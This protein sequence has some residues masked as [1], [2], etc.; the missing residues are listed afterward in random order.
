[1]AKDP[2]LLLREQ[3]Q[4]VW[5][6]YIRR[7]ELV[8]SEFRALVEGGITGVTSNPTIFEKAVAGSNDYDDAFR[9]FAGARLDWKQAL[10]KL[11]SDD[12]RMAADILRPVYD[13]TGGND[14]FVSIEEDPAL[15]YDTAR[16][17]KEAGR[18]REL[19]GRQNVLIKI[20]STPAGIA[21]A[22]EAIY[23]GININITLMFSLQAYEDTARAYI[24]GLQRRLEAGLPVNT[25]RSVASFF[26]SRVDTLVDKLLEEKIAAASS[27]AERDRLRAMLGKAAIANAKEAYQR[28]L[29]IFEGDEFAR[30]RAAGAAVQRVLWASTSTKNPA[31]RDILYAEQLI[32]PQTIDTM[33]PTTITGFRDHG[34]V[35]P[36]L[37][38]GIEEA[39]TTL[40]ELGKAGIDMDEVTLKLQRDGVESFAASWR[41]LQDA[42]RAKLSAVPI[43]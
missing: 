12:I 37:T 21:A 42:V 34:V 30:L 24:R 36:T 4:S 5:Y 11:V 9:E 1:M 6:D 31:Y 38:N 16:A 32:G 39:R 17:I 25:I 14:G 40:R 22:E 18:L 3:G 15:A 41:A 35:A 7:G 20:P 29:G 8:S 26:V 23:A 33:P 2:I 28:F 43:P 19:V 27:E 10:E 13:S